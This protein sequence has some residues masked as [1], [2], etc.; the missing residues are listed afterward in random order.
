MSSALTS[1]RRSYPRL[2]PDDLAMSQSADAL[3]NHHGVSIAT[4][5]ADWP[6]DP[7][8][9]CLPNS[10]WSFNNL[11]RWDYQG[12]LDMIRGASSLKTKGRR[13]GPDGIEYPGKNKLCAD[14]VSPY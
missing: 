11:R 2:L 12:F 4:L 14:L 7:Y 6:R 3:L 13:C 9:A 1:N 10:G 8:A 5:P